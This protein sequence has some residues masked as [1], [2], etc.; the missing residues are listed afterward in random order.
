MSKVKKILKYIDS[1][2]EYSGKLEDR[3]LKIDYEQ[4]NEERYFGM[5]IT[6]SYNTNWYSGDVLVYNSD[7]GHYF[8]FRDNF[9]C[10]KEEEVINVLDILRHFSETIGESIRQVRCD[11]DRASGLGHSQVDLKRSNQYLLTK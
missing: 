5:H 1:I 3:K 6:L 9:T 11:V 7:N 2:K 8:S 4:E 10:S